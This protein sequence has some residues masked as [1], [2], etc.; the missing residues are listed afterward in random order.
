MLILYGISRSLNLQKP[1]MATHS[2][3]ST[4][5]ASPLLHD[6][7]ENPLKAIRVQ[8]DCEPTYFLPIALLAALAMSSTAATSY[9]AYATLICA[10][11]RHCTGR[12]QSRYAGTI[13]I[14]T[15]VAN[16]CGI[17]VIGHVQSFSKRSAWLGLVG[18]LLARSLSAVM[19]LIGGKFRVDEQ[20]DNQT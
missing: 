14:T 11:P 9:Y 13:A 8:N 15:S 20:Y 10:D 18:W 2:R 12:E 4:D 1:K 6:D 7:A 3:H 17:L 19:L 16:V 5:E